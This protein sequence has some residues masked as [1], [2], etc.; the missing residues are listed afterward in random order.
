MRANSN[1][2]MSCEKPSPSFP[3]SRLARADARQKSLLLFLGA[4]LLEQLSR[5]DHARHHT[6]DREPDAAELFGD[7][8]HADA[9]EPEAAVLGAEDEA[10]VAELGELGD[11]RQRD[12][13]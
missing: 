6:A 11:Q 10:E 3:P 1:V 5:D 8:R 9:V 13:F 4:A 7:D 2:R 12:L